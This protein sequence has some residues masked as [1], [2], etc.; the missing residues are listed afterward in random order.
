MIDLDYLTQKA[1]EF[2][3]A[4]SAVIDT[5]DVQFVPDFRKSCEMNTCGNFGKTGCAHPLSAQ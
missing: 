1:K 3:A 2:G 4:A 5:A